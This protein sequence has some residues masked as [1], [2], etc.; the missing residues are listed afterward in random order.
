MFLIVKRDLTIADARLL[1]MK[2]LNYRVT[3]DKIIFIDVARRY[4]LTRYCHDGRNPDAILIG[5]ARPEK[6]RD[7]CI[8]WTTKVITAWEIDAKTGKVKD[9]PAEGVSCYLDGYPDSC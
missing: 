7:G 8:H 1:L 3:G 6:E 9:V 4:G 5:L 2:V